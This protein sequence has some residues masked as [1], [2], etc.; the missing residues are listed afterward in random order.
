MI[1]HSPERTIAMLEQS[2]RAYHAIAAELHDYSERLIADG[3]TTFNDMVHA[4][5]PTEW[6]ELMSA[7]SKRAFEENVQQMARIANMYASAAS[8]QTRAIQSLLLPMPR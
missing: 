8:E 5:T 4:G 6:I 2:S 7:F 1:E 3:T